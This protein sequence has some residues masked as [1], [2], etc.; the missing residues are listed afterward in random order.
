VLYLGMP[1]Q[2]SVLPGPAYSTVQPLTTVWGDGQ[3]YRSV[4][5]SPTKISVFCERHQR[6]NTF[7]T[8]GYGNI[9][10]RI[11]PT[12]Y[13]TAP[14]YTYSADPWRYT[15]GGVWSRYDSSP[16]YSARVTTTRTCANG[17]CR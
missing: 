17:R 15:G 13:Y 12:V 9:V 1:S 3:A 11:M 16:S 8:D 4:R 10:A 7:R 5:M 6:W 2:Q 14:V